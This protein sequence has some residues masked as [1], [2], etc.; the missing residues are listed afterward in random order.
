MLV[1]ASFAI[2]QTASAACGPIQSGTVAKQMKQ[3][4]VTADAVDAGKTDVYTVT[5]SAGDHYIAVW[6]PGDI[7]LYICKGTSTTPVC[8][9]HNA[10]AT[11][12]GCLAAGLG[13]WPGVGAPVPGPGTFKIH[14]QHCTTADCGYEDVPAPLPYTLFVG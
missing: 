14:V 7:D 11:P 13:S 5:L 8:Q 4:Y 1:A 10:A 2:P 6:S 3:Q 12:D 9:S